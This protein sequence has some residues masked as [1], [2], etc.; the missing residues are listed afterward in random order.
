MIE[1]TIHPDF[2]P[3]AKALEQQ[4]HRAPMAG[5]AAVTVYHR[6]QRV[7]DIRGGNRDDAGTAW[8][9]KT[10][11]VSFSTTKGVMSTILHRLVDQGLFDYDDQVVKLWPEFG[12]HGKDAI[13]IRHLLCHQAGLYDIRHM[14]DAAERM[15][16]WEYMTTAIAAAV[17][18]HRPGA[19]S[20]YH[21]LTYG[22]LIG[23]VVQR[24]TNRTVSELAQSEIA[25]PLGL[26][27]LYIGVPDEQIKRVAKLVL[28]TERLARIQRLEGPM[29]T[30]QK[31][32]SFVR[33]PIDAGRMAA[34]LAPPGIES[35]DW[36][37]PA[38]LRAVIPAANGVFTARSLAKMYAVLAAG[39]ELDGVRLLS[40]ETLRRATEIQSRKIDRVVP[41]PMHWRLGYHRA[42]TTRGNPARGFG[43]YGFGGSGAW[44]DPDHQLAVAMILNSGLGTPFGDIR[45]AQIGGAALQCA[46][47]R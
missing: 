15:L 9:S 10:M 24:A 6:G 40:P 34:A 14:V 32:L 27:G 38:T 33:F 31:A 29:R 28:P 23:E 46:R 39:G 26:D 36:S 19:M 1:G 21:G 20:A 22:W 17:P 18:K 8:T 47:R 11:S 3:V 13:T 12:Q 41:F 42:A 37:A 30:L 2:W 43:H 44:A 16:D 35:F 4:L 25:D 7:V 45:T 5:G